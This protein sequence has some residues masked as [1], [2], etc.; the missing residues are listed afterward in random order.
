MKNTRHIIASLML[1]APTLALAAT[2]VNLPSVYVGVNAVLKKNGF[3]TGYGDNTFKSKQLMAN[4]FV[5]LDMLPNLNL[6]VNLE[7]TMKRKRESTLSG[8]DVWLGNS[9]E[10]QTL[11]VVGDIRMS[12]IGLD[13]IYK[14]NPLCCEKFNLLFATGMKILK[15]DLKTYASDEPSKYVKLKDGN[16]KTIFKLTSGYEYMF[17]NNYGMRG[18]ISWEN[19]SALKPIGTSK[20]GARFHA[21][22][23]NSINYTFGILY[24][25]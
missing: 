15:V 5:G 12:S 9:M 7:T 25:F 22:L 13:L 20:T 3:T 14:F 23:K 19:T 6:E 4:L 1:V 24:E 10:G 11:T 17:T 8:N 16:V 18:L 2:T 21:K